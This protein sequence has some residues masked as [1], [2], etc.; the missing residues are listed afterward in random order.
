MPTIGDG[1]S[2]VEDW[3]DRYNRVHYPATLPWAR[4]KRTVHWLK[5]ALDQSSE[6]REPHY[7]TDEASHKKAQRNG[8]Q[9]AGSRAGLCLSRTETGIVPK[10]SQSRMLK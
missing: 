3:I 7:L 6:S 2:V 10:Y 5:E 8:D 9:A 1:V 4:F